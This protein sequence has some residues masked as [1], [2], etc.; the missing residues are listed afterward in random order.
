MR[1]VAVRYMLLGRVWLAGLSTKIKD[2]TKL[3]LAL[4]HG[5]EIHEPRP[6]TSDAWDVRRSCEPVV[7]TISS[8]QLAC[9]GDRCLGQ[10]EVGLHFYAF[11]CRPVSTSAYYNF[12]AHTA[13]GV[14]GASYGPPESGIEAWIIDFVPSVVPCEK[15]CSFICRHQVSDQKGLSRKRSTGTFRF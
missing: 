9:T 5:S 6:S 14:S 10:T 12:Q 1:A 13:K 4:E 3:D 8:L 11:D 2:S 15:T 7:N